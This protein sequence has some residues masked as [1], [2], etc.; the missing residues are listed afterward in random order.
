[1]VSGSHYISG[2]KERFGVEEANLNLLEAKENYD[3]VEDNLLFQ[4]KDNFIT[5]QTAE[6]LMEL[7]RGGIIPQS[8]LSLE[9]AISGYQ[10]GDVDFLT[11]LN[12]LITLFNF[13]L[14][15]YDQLTV[16]QKALVKI[17]ELS[18]M[19]IISKATLTSDESEEINHTIGDDLNE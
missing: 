18:G 2:K 13:E 15:Y 17:E 9:S 14:E 1:L 3:A 7:Y 12:N 5:A 8:S 6:K 19:E 10:V 4:V 16:Y 11:L